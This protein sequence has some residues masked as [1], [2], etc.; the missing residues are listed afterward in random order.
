MKFS[1]AQKRLIKKV[2]FRVFILISVIV[3]ASYYMIYRYVEERE[4]EIVLK[5]RYTFAVRIDSHGNILEPAAEN[6]VNHTL[7]DDF[8]QLTIGQI[9]DIWIR[10]FTSQYTQDRK[11]V[12]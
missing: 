4:R 11:S 12:V 7:A 3:M 5:S 6:S 10:Q 8:A 1:A 2:A 9:G